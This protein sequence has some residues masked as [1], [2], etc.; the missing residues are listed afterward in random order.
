MG[1]FLT[2]Y[3]DKFLSFFCLIFLGRVSY[4]LPGLA[5]DFDPPTRTSDIAGITYLYH[6]SFPSKGILSVLVASV[7]NPGGS[8][9]GPQ[10]KPA[11]VR[12][13]SLGIPFGLLHSFKH[14]YICLG[15]KHIEEETRGL[16]IKH[17]SLD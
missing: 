2:S 13:A 15:T 6:G 5:L 17:I 14:V 7:N 4:F 10:K 3:S 8:P 1:Y 9:L 16:W 11:R 12:S